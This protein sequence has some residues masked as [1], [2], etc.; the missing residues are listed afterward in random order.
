MHEIRDRPVYFRVNGP[1]G[2]NAEKGARRKTRRETDS[3]TFE[4]DCRSS[5]TERRANGKR[6][7]RTYACTHKRFSHGSPRDRSSFGAFP[8]TYRFSFPFFLFVVYPLR[9]ADAPRRSP[10]YVRH[11]FKTKNEYVQYEYTRVPTTA[12]VPRARSIIIYVIQCAHGTICTYAT[13]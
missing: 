6:T 9:P 3:E 12:S 1:A 2:L 7:R 13:H 5:A 8:I 4:R 11:S 10:L